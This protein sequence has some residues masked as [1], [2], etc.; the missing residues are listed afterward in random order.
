M[1]GAGGCPEAPVAGGT[2]CL[3]GDSESPSNARRLAASPSRPSACDQ[4]E[5][6][7]W[8]PFEDSGPP[9][10]EPTGL[11]PRGAGAKGSFLHPIESHVQ[12]CFKN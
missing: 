5:I 7:P 2:C 6:S 1:M 8:T 10:G 4:E 11:V 12:R 9:R 3:G